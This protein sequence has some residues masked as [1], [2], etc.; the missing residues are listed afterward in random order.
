MF[1]N[2]KRCKLLFSR[3]KVYFKKKLSAN[4]AFVSL[5]DAVVAFTYIDMNE[6][7]K[8]SMKEFIKLGRDFFLTDDQTKPSKHFWGP[9]VD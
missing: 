8:L 5:Q 3:L 7:G 4:L 9:L 6:D 1:G 2:G